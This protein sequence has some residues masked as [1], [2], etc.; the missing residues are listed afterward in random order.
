MFGISAVEILIFLVVALLLIR[1]LIDV[2]SRLDL[3]AYAYK[4]RGLRTR[5]RAGAPDNTGLI[6]AVIV[7]LAA[8]VV[9]YVASVAT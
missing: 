5:V 6:V 1:R 4:Y 9:F 7:L 3:Y 2:I 8:A